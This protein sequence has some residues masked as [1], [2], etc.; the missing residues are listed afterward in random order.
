M[1]KELN[2]IEKVDAE[3][4]IS[5][6]IPFSD[7]A[8][9]QAKI[10][11]GAGLGGIIGYKLNKGAVNYLLR[12]RAPNLFS[13]NIKY[14]D[15]EKTNRAK[16][17]EILFKAMAMPGAFIGG[18]TGALTANNF[19]KNY[20][21]KKRR[22]ADK[23]NYKTDFQGDVI[24]KKARYQNT[25][26]AREGLNKAFKGINDS[27]FHPK[28]AY[29]AGFGALLGHHGGKTISNTKD[30]WDDDKKRKF[31]TGATLVGA[32]L[33]AIPL[34]SSIRASQKYA[35]EFENAYKGF[36]KSMNKGEDETLKI[37]GLSKKSNGIFKLDGARVTTK[38][39]LKKV[40]RNFYKKHH[41][42][43]GGDPKRFI[44]GRKIWDNL[45]N[46]EEFQK[47]AYFYAK[48]RP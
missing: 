1:G 12:K 35:D 17:I 20:I 24:E 26:Q 27:I 42:D 22:I 3:S 15:S 36:Y 31:T 40:F 19:D 29:P 32:S 46:S 18:I 39:E 28:N 34:A 7:K 37:L 43:Q 10:L 4:K 41:P 13:K 8:V 6:K 47:L 30:N 14:V 38:A 16:D 25:S 11:G 45:K 5:K 44:L 9:N 33:G 48:N 2:F 23:L 21:N